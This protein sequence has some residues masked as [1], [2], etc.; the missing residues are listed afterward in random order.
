[1]TKIEIYGK[2]SV[3]FLVVAFIPIIIGLID[4]GSYLFVDY[5][6]STISYDA[7]R[8]SGFILWLFIFGFFSYLT[9]IIGCNDTSGKMEGNNANGN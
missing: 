9:L 5:K 3:I 8:V 1:M 2:V 7:H 6:L 4:L